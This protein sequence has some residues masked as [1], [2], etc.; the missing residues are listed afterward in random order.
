VIVQLPLVTDGKISRIMSQRSP[1]EKSGF[2]SGLL[3]IAIMISSKSGWL[4]LMMSR[5]P[6]VGGSN[7]PGIWLGAY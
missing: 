3:R 5:C 6:F 1:T 7:E 2:L 4:R